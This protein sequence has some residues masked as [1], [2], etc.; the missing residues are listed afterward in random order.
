MGIDEFIN[1]IQQKKCI[2]VGS[3]LQGQRMIDLME[4]WGVVNN[5]IAFADNN[6]KNKGK[7][8]L[9]RKYHYPILSVI[10]SI[11]LVRKNFIYIITC[12]DIVGVKN[13]LK[14]FEELNDIPCVSLGELGQ[15][16]LILSD[17]PGIIFE[18]TKPVIPKKIHYCW[19]GNKMPVSLENNIKQWA[20]IC[21]DY[22]IIRWDV[23]NYNIYINQYISQAYEMKKWAYVSDYLRLDVIYK[24]GGIYLDTDIEIVQK[25]DP[26]LYQNC[27]ACFD[28]TLMVNSG[29]GIGS[30]PKL[31]IIKELKEIY[32]NMPFE[33][34]NGYYNNSSCMLHT[35][36]VLKKYGIKMNDTLQTIAGINI[37]PSIFQGT[38]CSTHQ[39]RITNK[40]FFLHY[41]TTSWIDS[42]SRK[43]KEKAA[44]FYASAPNPM[45]QSY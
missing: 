21:P 19:F 33:L 16:Q 18:H 14:E 22:E 41:G 10:D 3:G 39:K 37:Y 45:L 36:S 30:I 31:P 27:F 15:Q 13:Q 1:F 8:F 43:N 25:P 28:G 44:Q 20:K 32:E 17:Y 5:I 40:T 7:D 38:N 9:Y 2:C 42:I 24:Y 34:E 4:N 35:Y 23:T 6:V 26:L 11:K 29:S 12:S